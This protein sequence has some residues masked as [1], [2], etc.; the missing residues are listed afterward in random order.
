M[1][2]LG[3]FVSPNGNQLPVLKLQADGVVLLQ[4]VHVAFETT[5]TKAI[6]NGYRLVDASDDLRSTWEQ[7][8]DRIN[9]P[10]KDYRDSH[11][12]HS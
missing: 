10:A 3:L 7:T 12:T 6:Q 2:N 1:Q 5:I 11:P 4:G 9:P 8:Q